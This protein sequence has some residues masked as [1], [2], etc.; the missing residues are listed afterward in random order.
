MVHWTLTLKLRLLAFK[1]GGIFI[2]SHLLWH[3]TSVFA[4]SSD[5]LSHLVALYDRQMVLRF[6]SFS[7]HDSFAYA[8]LLLAIAIQV[9][10]VTVDHIIDLLFQNLL[11][12]HENGEFYILRYKNNYSVCILELHIRYINSKLYRLLILYEQCRKS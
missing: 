4:V 6:Y 2:V 9:N 1:Q 3:G 5:G 11:H 8:C 10:I 7:N 12:D